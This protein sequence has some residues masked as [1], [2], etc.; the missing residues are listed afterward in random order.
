M[1]PSYPA[2]INFNI[3]N[4][5]GTFS[6]T[7]IY[8]FDGVVNT[9]AQPNKALKLK[10]SV[11]INHDLSLN[12]CKTDEGY[13]NTTNL[14]NQNKKPSI[15]T[16]KV[17]SRSNIVDDKSY[18]SVNMGG[19]P[20]LK[21]AN[22]KQVSLGNFK[23]STKLRKNVLVVEAKKEPDKVLI[24]SESSKK[25]RKIDYV[26]SKVNASE[27]KRYLNL[28]KNQRQLN[29]TKESIISECSMSESRNE[30]E[31][32]LSGR[33]SNFEINFNHEQAT[34]FNEP[35]FH[36]AHKAKNSILSEDSL[37]A[38]LINFNDQQIQQSDNFTKNIQIVQ[39]IHENSAKCEWRIDYKN[40]AYSNSLAIL[41]SKELLCSGQR[42]KILSKYRSCNHSSLLNLTKIKLLAEYKD[43]LNE[44]KINYF[45][46]LNESKAELSSDFKISSTANQALMFIKEKSEIELIQ[47]STSLEITS[48]LIN[49]FFSLFIILVFEF[50]PIKVVKIETTENKEYF[51]NMDYEFD[52]T[53][54]ITILEFMGI[55]IFIDESVCTSNRENCLVNTVELFYML[56]EKKYHFKSIS[57]YSQC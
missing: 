43:K 5:V 41:L 19:I 36:Q 39:R 14:R 20:D 17:I 48:S 30:M 22:L 49:R 3:I 9:I 54:E 38:P 7:N 56:Q 45:Y 37:Q 44:L 12:D 52:A 1:N 8:G 6:T 28:N 34:Q 53:K 26:A 16:P 57:K 11:T 18:S 35:K 10:N 15:I 2:A 50:D 13:S 27:V 32:Q 31:S 21:K 40:S 4:Q 42:L 55:E 23:E 46:Y 51:L 24:K 29:E 25:I 47:T 33:Y